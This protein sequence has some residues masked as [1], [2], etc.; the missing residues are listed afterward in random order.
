[1]DRTCG[2]RRSTIDFF[3]RFAILYRLKINIIIDKLICYYLFAIIIVDI[4]YIHLFSCAYNRCGYT[5]GSVNWTSFVQ[6][7]VDRFSVVSD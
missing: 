1:M 3:P 7:N 4:F 2:K 6:S 5:I